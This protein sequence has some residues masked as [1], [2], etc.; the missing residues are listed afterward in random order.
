MIRVTTLVETP[1]GYKPVD[2]VALF[3]E[4][5]ADKK[6]SDF[7]RSTRNAGPGIIYYN[8]T[9][10]PDDVRSYTFKITCVESLHSTVDY[11]VEIEKTNKKILGVSCSEDG[12]RCYKGAITRSSTIKVLESLTYVYKPFA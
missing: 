7:E 5:I 8:I 1:E 11:S 4:C 12:W 10:E 2:L 9:Y 6:V 3:E